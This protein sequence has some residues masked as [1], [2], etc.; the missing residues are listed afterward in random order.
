MAMAARAALCVAGA[1]LSLWSLHVGRERARDPHYRAGCDLGPAMSCSRVFGSRWGRGLGLV[2]PLLGP[3]SSFNL[4]NGVIGVFFYLLQGVLGTGW[5][6]GRGATAV[7]L[8][9]SGTSVLAS[10]WLG[11]VLAFELQDLCLVCVSTYLIN[12][13]LLLLNWCRWRRSQHPKTA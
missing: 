5:V 4:S 11:W 1:A 6:P 13:L 8:G 3:D 7:L 12:I 10:V 9:T 2:E